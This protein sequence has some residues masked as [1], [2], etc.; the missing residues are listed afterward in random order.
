MA[1]KKKIKKASSSKL[2][3]ALTMDQGYCRMNIESEEIYMS[4]YSENYQTVQLKRIADI[5]EEILKLVK[6]DMEPKK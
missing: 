5:L 6:K 4:M 1:R 3:A 2:Q